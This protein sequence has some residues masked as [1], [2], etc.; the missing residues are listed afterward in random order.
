MTAPGAIVLL[1]GG[2]D[3]VTVLAIAQSEGYAPLALS[4][5]YGQRHVVELRCAAWQAESI[6][7]EMLTLKIDERLFRGTALVDRNI[8]VP[9]DR[10]IDDQIPVTYVP[11]RNTLFLAHALALAES[12]GIG[13]I[14]LG[15]NA[16][17]YSGYPDC[18]P[19]FLEAFAT[20][21]R[22]ATRDG[23]EGRAIKLHAPLI[24]LNKA[25]II[26]CGLRLGVRYEYS[27]SCYQPGLDGR[28]C[29]RCDSCQ[30][31]RRGFAEAGVDD[32]LSAVPP[33]QT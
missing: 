27:S 17:D 31:R 15:I 25:Q 23:V 6:G 32:P 22:L 33:S 2:L 13:H 20:L 19:E 3:S 1:S 11:A 16:L 9:L 4:F 29:G 10:A 21:A 12:R 5:D 26:Q 30:L 28:P 7:A 8:A 24:K 18:R 14:F